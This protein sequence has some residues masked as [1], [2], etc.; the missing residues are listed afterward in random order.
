MATTSA[1][2]GGLKGGGKAT[3]ITKK[4]SDRADFKKSAK[5][6]KKPLSR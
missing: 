2:L 4:P 6:T 3:R 1:G 5:P